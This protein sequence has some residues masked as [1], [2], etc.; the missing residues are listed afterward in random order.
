[1][2]KRFFGKSLYFFLYNRLVISLPESSHDLRTTR[3]YLVARGSSSSNGTLA[4][5]SPIGSVYFRQDQLHIDLFVFFSVFFSCFFLFLSVCIVVYKAK[6]TLEARRE[7][8]RA[9]IELIHLARRPFAKQ[10]VLL[11]ENGQQQQQQRQRHHQQQQRHHGRIV[12]PPIMGHQHRRVGDSSSSANVDVPIFTTKPLAL[13]PLSV[14]SG[15]ASVATVLIR[16]P[17]AKG[18]SK[19]SF[20]CILASDSE[21]DNKASNNKGKL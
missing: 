14:G 6:A 10:M 3:F 7:R 1:M 16:L 19:L 17:E 11:G 21:V 15:S 13:E 9:E 18:S 5:E 2:E 20:G 8:Q 4:S 12:L